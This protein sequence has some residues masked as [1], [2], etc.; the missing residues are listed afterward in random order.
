MAFPKEMEKEKAK[1][2]KV[3]GRKRGRPKKLES[4][5]ENSGGGLPFFNPYGGKG[6][7]KKKF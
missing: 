7:K 3:P 4:T 1:K 2:P 6:Q 5:S